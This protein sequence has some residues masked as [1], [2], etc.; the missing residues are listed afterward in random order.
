MEN[1]DTN[2]LM[3]VQKLDSRD[4]VFGFVSDW[5]NELH[6]YVN[7]LYV[8]ALYKGEYRLD[9]KIEV[10]SLGKEKKPGRIR[11]VINLYRLVI[12]LA[13]KGKINGIFVFQGGWYPV[14]LWPIKKIFAIKLVQWKVHS[15]VNFEMKLNMLA[16]DTILTAAATCFRKDSAK[17]KGI[18]HG[19]DTEKFKRD[20][21]AAKRDL[22]V[23]VGRISAIKRLKEVIRMFALLAAEKKFKDYRLEFYG[24]PQTKKDRKY[25]AALKSLVDTLGLAFCLDFKG[26]VEHHELARIYSEA[27]VSLNIG[28]I[29]SLDKAILESMACETP[30]VMCTPAIKDQL[31]EYEGLLY[32]AQDEDILKNLK[33]ILA[34]EQPG[35]EK[36]GRALRR[37]VVENHN[38]ANLMQ[39]IAHEFQVH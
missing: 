31:G 25:F 6:K 19:I 9:E 4:S 1:I 26:S 11:Y 27:R 13:K 7:R 3:I 35:Y 15:V 36:M 33:R 32:A 20:S 10:F 37:I 2:L 12:P 29:G 18:G 21:R 8:L 24:L 34:M 38:L 17:I 22:V 14:L 30:V 23:V 5:I 39:R 28:N 16:V